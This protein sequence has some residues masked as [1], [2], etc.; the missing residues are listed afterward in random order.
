MATSDRMERGRPLTI[1]FISILVLILVGPALESIGRGRLVYLMVGAVVPFAAVYAV[2]RSKHEL[3]VAMIMAVPSALVGVA[4]QRFTATAFDWMLL[5]FPFVFYVYATAIIARRVFRVRRVTTDTL[6]GAGCVYVLLGII[7]WLAYNAVL[8]ID[9][10]A[11]AGSGLTGA[12]GGVGEG[13]LLYF[14]YV[15]LTT[16]GYGDITPVSE[17]ARSLAIVEAVVGVLF[18]MILVARLVGQYASSARAD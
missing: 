2:S 9:P 6:A 12:G 15:T 17:T 3:H 4:A 1:F 13:D 8:M 14:S 16:L 18:G 10:S 11:L 7:W 5:A